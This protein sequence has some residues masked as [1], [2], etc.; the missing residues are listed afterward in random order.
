MDASEIAREFQGFLE[1]T[2]PLCGFKNDH[3]ACEQIFETTKNAECRDTAESA[4]K[5]FHKL[6]GQE[7]FNG[8]GKVSLLK[9]ETLRNDKLYKITHDLG[10]LARERHNYFMLVGVEKTEKGCQLALLAGW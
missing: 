6:E 4:V 3:W 2:P 8:I 5:K 10:G 9:V 1:S 7:S